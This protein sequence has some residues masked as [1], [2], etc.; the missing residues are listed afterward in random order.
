MKTHVKKGDNVEVIA[1][2]NKGKRGVVLSVNAK[3]QTV[4]VEG[5]RKLI[6]KAVSRKSTA[7]STSPM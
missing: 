5:A 6:P 7:P 1:G 4:T 2:K 3:K